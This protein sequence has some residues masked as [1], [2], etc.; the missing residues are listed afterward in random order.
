MS[1]L[2]PAHIVQSPFFY[3][4]GNTPAVCLTQSLPPDQDAALLLLGCGD[5]RNILF[6]IYSGISTD[7]RKLDFTCC[8][9]LAEIIARN[10]LIL[11]L[12][13]DDATGARTQQLW[14]IY[15]H[16]FIDNES[17][18]ILQTQ[19][20]N[21]LKHAL[22]L[23]T[24]EQGPYSRLV[25]FSDSITFA[26]VIKLWEL[27]ATT[28]SDQSNYKAVQESVK[29][30]WSNAR[31]IQKSKI[32]TNG[33]ILDGVRSSAPLVQQALVDFGKGYQTFWETGTCLDDKKITRKLSIANPMFLCLRKD[34]ILHYGTDPLFGFHLAPLYSHLSAESPLDPN[35]S[36]FKASPKAMNLAM[37]QFF[38]WSN[39]FRKMSD[40]V[41]VRYVNSDA[42]AFCHVLQHQRVHGE[43]HSANWYRNN[44]G[45]SRLTLDS[46]DYNASGKAP[47]S[48]NVIDT[49]NLT[50][51]L[52]ILNILA[53]AGPLLAQHSAATLRTEILIPREATV[54]ESVRTLL[55]GDLPTVALIL[56]LKPAQYWTNATATWHVNN[57]LDTN[58][59]FAKTVML[60]LSRHIILW[61]P[62]ELANIQWD[63]TSL[64]DFIFQVYLEMFRDENLNRK[65][66]IL[67]IADHDMLERKIH[68]FEVY[69]RASFAALLQNVKISGV[70]AWHSLIERLINKVLF[71]QTLIIG[72]HHYQS[73]MVHLDMLGLSSLDL[74]DWWHPKNC[75]YELQSGPFRGWV[76]IPSTVCITLAVPRKAVQKF[77]DLSNGTP[78]CHIM[79]QSSISMKQ[80]IYSD[81]QL[82]FGTITTSGKVF[83]DDYTLNIEEDVQ[84]WQGKTPLIVSTMVSTCAL[85]NEGDP[86][87]KIK[88]ALKN[89]PANVS[90][91]LRE[92][93]MMLELYGSAVGQS[94]VFVTKYRP[95]MTGKISV[96][97]PSSQQ[98]SNININPTTVK[99]SFDT[100]GNRVSSLQ[101]H[102][103]ITSAKAITLLQGGASV[104]MH[105]TDPFN[106]VLNISSGS[107]TFQ[108]SLQL[109]MPLD[110]S[111]GKTKIARKSLY[112]EFSAP[113]AE[114]AEMAKRPDLVFPMQKDARSSVIALQ[115]L[116]YV[117]A[118]VL[119]KLH[120]GT[121]NS[122][123]N[124]LSSHI[125]PRT[126]MSGA[127]NREYTTLTANK[128]LNMPGRLG[129]KNSI[130]N[131]YAHLFGIAGQA[132]L[133]IFEF[134]TPTTI[135]GVLYAESVRMDVSNQT[136]FIDAAFIPFHSGP[137]MKRV[138][139]L[140]GTRSEGVVGIKM[141][142]D[143]VA[144]WKYILPAFAERCRQWLHK[145]AC[146]YKTTERIPLSIAH[147]K[148]YMCS[149]GLGVFPENYLKDL[150]KSKQL[151]KHAVRVAVPIIFASPINIDDAGPV[152]RSSSYVQ[153]ILKQGPKSAPPVGSRIGDLDAKKGTCF[154]CSATVSKAGSALSRC[155]RCQV[156]QYCSADCQGK[157]WKK[158]K[159]VCKQLQK[160]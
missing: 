146:E 5:V 60:G 63:A 58:I 99:P 24:W 52:G 87:C 27:Y 82:G 151:L 159:Q 72:A 43:S 41:R 76:N 142:D 94:N 118:D 54:S 114:P 156:A 86:A 140:L 100:A 50:D 21:L 32:G 117:R 108:K 12:V 77:A 145:P 80:N 28:R 157:D 130:Q 37:T 69:T 71:D 158:H 92:L 79:T 26:N 53:A 59:S 40:R 25:T 129:I 150:K 144:F 17:L 89:T 155:S 18:R 135:F 115:Q 45:Y 42:I 95:H 66:G 102:F 84:N 148:H 81:V 153:P 30:Q 98:A 3:P 149:C 29:I 64:A 14:N 34:L 101:V 75:R 125:S 90:N 97:C 103:K 35:E 68:A 124:W 16:V 11:T 15:Y 136:V 93:G 113:I 7:D 137:E 160:K 96:G 2:K 143:E 112:I 119:P 1:S 134:S 70:V 57:S 141:K 55:S 133:R 9:L 132:Q 85:V 123:A 46:S 127:E 109:T 78:L 105:L 65:L 44:W 121:N 10:T 116:H 6:T 56:G 120:M 128:S 138:G 62:A 33:I 104:G 91:F 83:S 73:L 88:F 39:A 31:E 23:E 8:D 106:M 22:S 152:A 13:L 38:A 36:S 122:N 67:R 111:K 61:K 147:D 4:A 19:A 154:G 139:A 47:T 131:I 126:T 110:L 51:H 49:S 107:D 74:Y 20:K 48:F